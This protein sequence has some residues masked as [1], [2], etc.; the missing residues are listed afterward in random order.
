MFEQALQDLGLRKPP[1]RDAV[2]RL[3]LEMARQI[4][5]G[6]LSPYLGSKR[7]WDLTLLASD[8]VVE[9]LDPFIYAASEWEERPNERDFFEAAIM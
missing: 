8:E 5:R 6:E 4:S 7:I 9:E 1:R 2:L 3:A